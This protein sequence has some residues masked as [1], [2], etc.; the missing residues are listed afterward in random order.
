MEGQDAARRAVDQDRLLPGEDP[1]SRNPEDAHHWVRVYDELHRF[2]LELIGQARS[3]MDAMN[4][5]AQVELEQVDLAIMQAE[6]DRL[7][8]R[9]G[10]W[11]ERLN[12]L[13]AVRTRYYR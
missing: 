4:P 1:R 10:Y 12:E 6:A 7:G 8:R 3:R 5:T 11:K 13:S 9:L 2:K